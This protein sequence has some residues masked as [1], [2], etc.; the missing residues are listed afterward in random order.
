VIESRRMSFGAA[1]NTHWRDEKCR[2]KF[3]RKFLR[4]EPFGLTKFVWKGK[5]KS[6]LKQ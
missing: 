5:L 2:H 4:E 6:I 3:N 1:Y